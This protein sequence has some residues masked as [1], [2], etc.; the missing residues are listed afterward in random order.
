MRIQENLTFLS[1]Y[2]CQ[3]PI[4]QSPTTAYYLHEKFPWQEVAHTKAASQVSC[5]QTLHI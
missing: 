5:M 1:Q 2:R 3:G 4:L